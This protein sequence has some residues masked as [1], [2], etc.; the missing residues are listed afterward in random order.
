MITDAMIEALLGDLPTLVEGGR[1]LRDAECRQYA[2][3][4]IES[5]LIAMWQPIE[6]HKKDEERFLA[7]EL[8][9]E[10]DVYECWWDDLMNEWQSDFGSG[11]EPSHWAPLLRPLPSPLEKSE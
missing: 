10:P 7:Y 11:L 5:A 1:V 4:A 9:H 6:T 8:G 3:Y 2:A